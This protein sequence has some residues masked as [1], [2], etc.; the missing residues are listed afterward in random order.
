MIHSLW[1]RVYWYVLPVLS[2]LLIALSFPKYSWSFLAWGCL[3]PLLFVI[4][5]GGLLRSLL[6]GC[7]TG[8]TSSSI[9]LYWIY[10]T[11]LYNL[12][13]WRQSLAALVLLSLYLAL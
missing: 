8:F 10:P 12:N 9:I 5:R 7:I 1:K 2:G 4:T 11:L 6:S 3:I 13:D